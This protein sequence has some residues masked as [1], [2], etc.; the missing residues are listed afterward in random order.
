[1]KLPGYI[2]CAAVCVVMMSSCGGSDSVS[3]AMAEAEFVAGRHESAGVICDSLI[4]GPAFADLSVDEL[5][6]LSVLM[7]QLA[8]YEDEEAN[9]ALAAKCMQAAM[10]QNADSVMSFVH[11]LPAD[12]QSRTLFLRQL[13]RMIDP[14]CDHEGQAARLSAV[15]DSINEFSE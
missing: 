7:S 9:M 11:S 3:V 6:R 1:M 12:E 8:E 2:I 13:T 4:Q 14:S 15:K 5:C 10:L